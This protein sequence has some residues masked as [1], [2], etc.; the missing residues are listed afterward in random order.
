MQ[1]YQLVLKFIIFNDL[2][3]YHEPGTEYTNWSEKSRYLSKRPDEAT[4]VSEFRYAINSPI[5][6]KLQFLA[7]LEYSLKIFQK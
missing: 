4:N 1:Q 6:D 5:C 2:N 7:V 3:Y